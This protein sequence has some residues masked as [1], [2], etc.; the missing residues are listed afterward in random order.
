MPV[1]KRV[2]TDFV[3]NTET[4]GEQTNHSIR[5]LTHRR[6]H[7]R[8]TCWSELLVAVILT[9][10]P[11]NFAFAQ[12]YQGQKLDQYEGRKLEQGDYDKINDLRSEI[13]EKSQ[14]LHVETTREFDEEWENKQSR[15]LKCAD[16]NNRGGY[17]NS[18][19]VE[20]CQLNNTLRYINYLESYLSKVKQEGATQIALS[21][22][23]SAQ[24]AGPASSETATSTARAEVYANDIAPP[25]NAG[26]VN[27]NSDENK[28][29]SV[30]NNIGNNPD[31]MNSA[32]DSLTILFISILLLPFMY[33][34]VKGFS[35]DWARS[36]KHESDEI[37]DV[38]DASQTSDSFSSLN[39]NQKIIRNRSLEKAL[40]SVDFWDSMRTMT[41]FALSYGATLF[42]VFAIWGTIVAGWIGVILSPIVIPCIIFYTVK[43]RRV[44]EK[45]QQEFPK[46]KAQR[47][48]KKLF[49][50][51][52]IFTCF[53][54]NAVFAL[55]F[56]ESDRT[57]VAAVPRHSTR[58]AGTDS[59]GRQRIIERTWTEARYTYID[60]TKCCVCGEHTRMKREVTKE[61]NVRSHE[62]MG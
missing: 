19:E 50:K 29:N 15:D 32:R 40:S 3:V 21:A 62:R 47:T 46:S 57:L 8:S 26:F 20:Q 14:S 33:F 59:N 27:S 49:D 16:I 56:W 42:S 52:K 45:F 54:C 36:S 30:F 22:E 17:D 12:Q 35:E 34:V 41:L 58:S 2:G 61:E 53:K 25:S 7:A 43:V 44:L 48:K 5:R 51:G 37:N 38:F 18:L 39:D 31:N 13:F 55:S 9:F 24:G 11:I 10:C 60:N 4:S 28:S 6:T 1:L 23:N